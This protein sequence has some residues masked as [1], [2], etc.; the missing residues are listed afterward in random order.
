M[1]WAALSFKNKN[2]VCRRHYEEGS[3][4]YDATSV[5]VHF[6]RSV[7]ADAIDTA[8]N[9]SAACEERRRLWL[10][11]RAGAS[12]SVLSPSASK[13]TSTSACDA[14]AGDPN[15][16]DGGSSA[17]ATCAAAAVV[18]SE[19]G[20]EGEGVDDDDALRM[21]IPCPRVMMPNEDEHEEMRRP[22]QLLIP[23]GLDGGLNAH[24]V[25]AAAVL[26]D[27]RTVKKA[28]KTRRALAEKVSALLRALRP[29]EEEEESTAAPLGGN[30][31]GN[32]AGSSVDAAFDAAAAAVLRFVT[33]AGSPKWSKWRAALGAACAR[34]T[35]EGSVHALSS[36]STLD[37]DEQSLKTLEMKMMIAAAIGE[38][39]SGGARRRNHGGGGG[40]DGRRKDTWHAYAEG[41][42]DPRAGTRGAA[43]GGADPTSV[44]S[45]LRDALRYRVAKKRAM[46]SCERRAAA[47]DE[48]D[49]GINSHDANRNGESVAGAEL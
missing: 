31:D 1:T 40:G 47:R 27:A 7:G 34:A 4:P 14:A 16:D 36:M 12:P 6:Q 33:V 21:R 23:V 8:K 46:Q 41:F 26:L 44:L 45:R 39:H 5:F 13:S 24:A 37:Q 10:R 38:K 48:Q 19:G 49:G 20:G 29:A 17:S 15:D 35:S 30:D 11:R 18:P 22:P 2:V 3:N 28:G 43:R 42:Q 25:A 9:I 32:A